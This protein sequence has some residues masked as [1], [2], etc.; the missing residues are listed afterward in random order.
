M[1]ALMKLIFEQKNANSKFVVLYNV[2]SSLLNKQ[3][4]LITSKWQLRK[5]DLCFLVELTL[6]IEVPSIE[7]SAVK[8][9][10][11]LKHP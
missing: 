7:L 3:N 8:Q 10:F 4:K 2:V 1:V 6:A 5:E 11:I 9:E